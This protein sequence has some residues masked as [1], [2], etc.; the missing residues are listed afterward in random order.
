MLKYNRL[1]FLTAFKNH[2]RVKYE[3][4]KEAINPK[5]YGRTSSFKLG[6]SIKS[7]TPNIIVPKLIGIYNINEYLRAALLLISLNKAAIKVEP[8]LEI[9]GITDIICT[10]PINI[11]SFQVKSLSSLDP[12]MFFT[13]NKNN[14]VSKKE[15][16]TNLILFK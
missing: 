3:T 9:P 11:E 4:I 16:P 12:L 15:K 2:F 13:K 8:L 6:V 10:S 7:F 1:P 5:E 14:A